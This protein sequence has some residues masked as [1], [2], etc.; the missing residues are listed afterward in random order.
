MSQHPAA[1]GIR[2]STKCSRRFLQQ[3][4]VLGVRNR[5]GT[6]PRQRVGSFW[7]AKNAYGKLGIDLQVLQHSA[8]MAREI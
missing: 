6:P 2:R 7:R 8:G 1:S 4:P 5:R 3:I